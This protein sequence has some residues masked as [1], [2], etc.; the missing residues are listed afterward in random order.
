MFIGPSNILERLTADPPQAFELLPNKDYTF[1]QSPLTY[2]I[3]SSD[4]AMYLGSLAE[5]PVRV[6]YLALA[7]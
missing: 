4:Q 6:T 7:D 1:K 2:G 5:T 3:T